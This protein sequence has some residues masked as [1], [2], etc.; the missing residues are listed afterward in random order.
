MSGITQEDLLQ[1]LEAKNPVL[2]DLCNQEPDHSQEVAHQVRAQLLLDT[3]GT[4]ETAFTQANGTG[5]Q[6]KE[7]QQ[8]EKLVGKMEHAFKQA[9]REA[10]GGKQRYTGRQSGLP[11]PSTAKN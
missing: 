9:L 4:I 10:K 3:R 2:L 8:L 11:Q 1:K 7:A 5:L 6:W